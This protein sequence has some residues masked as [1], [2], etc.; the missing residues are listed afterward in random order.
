APK[1]DPTP[2]PQPE[3]PVVAQKPEPPPS[4]PEKPAEVAPEPARPTLPTVAV[5]DRVDGAVLLVAAD[6][7]VAAKS[8]QEI[9]WEQGVEVVGLG[10]Q[11]VV[12]YVDGTRLALG[13]DTQVLQL[14]ER[15][16]G[17][18]KRV[19]MSRGVLAAQVAKQPA[20]EAMV[21]T[22]PHA[23][24]RIMSTR[25]TLSVTATST[26]I[27]V[28]EGRVRFAR[29]D[30]GAAVE[31]GPNQYAV[32]GKGI[33]LSPKTVAGPRVALKEQFERP[34]LKW[35]PGWVQGADAG[36]GLRFANENGALSLRVPQKPASQPSPADVR[37][38]GVDVSRKLVSKGDWVR[39]IWIETKQSFALSNEAPLR[40]RA[41]L[42][43]SHSDDKRISWVALNRNVAG[44]SLL[45]ERRGNVLQLW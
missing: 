27:E 15:K 30:D 18:G 45:L 32:S 19:H 9:A 29:K 35:G 20:A 8:G 38:K 33:A 41:R 23:E 16:A 40:I 26:R 4:K 7:R 5:L 25:F 36:S 44:Q 14:T 10:S 6:A 21:F 11:A 31:V 39:S 43:Q 24:A 3:K 34:N 2:A 1:P 17:T 28:K 42:W 37:S 22:T 13:A 12:E